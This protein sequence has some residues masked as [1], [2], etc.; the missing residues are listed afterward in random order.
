MAQSTTGI[1]NKS[2]G[3]ELSAAEF[4]T[5][6]S[7]VDN[8]AND[9]EPR[10]GIP[11]NTTTVSTTTYTVLS[12]DRVVLIDDDTAGGDVTVN[13]PSAATL[14][15]GWA[16]T[17]KKTGT[18]GTVTVDPDGSETI[19]GASTKSIEQTNQSMA[20][21]SDG[22]VWRKLFPTTSN[23][24]AYYKDATYT[25]GSPLTLGNGVRTQLTIDGL[26]G[27]TTTDYLPDGV[28]AFWDTSAN[29][30]IPEKLGDS[31]DMRLDLVVDVPT[32]TETILIQLDIGSGAEINVVQRNVSFVESGAGQTVSI[33]FPIFC[34]ATFIANGGKIYLTA[35]SAGFD[36]YEAAIFLK[37]DFSP[38]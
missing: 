17:I 22:T 29:K 19:D 34:L 30:I 28:A 32:N 1:P 2:T 3:Q 11:G 4:N 33:G 31:Y 12:T 8:N 24:W 26:F 15:D 21:V 37:R 16:I 5:L 35:S 9:A 14:G 6:R 36:I 20:I 38:L 25:S 13:L 27:T 18:T 23:G 7:T 10:F